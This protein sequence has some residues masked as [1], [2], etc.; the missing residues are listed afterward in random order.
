L[1]GG[2][3]KYLGQGGGCGARRDWLIIRGRKLQAVRE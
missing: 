1:G 2:R 3:H